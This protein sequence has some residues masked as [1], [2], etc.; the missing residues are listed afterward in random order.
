MSLH[1]EQVLA[2]RLRKTQVRRDGLIEQ[3]FDVD[4]CPGLRVVCVSARD[5]VGEIEPVSQT[6]I[7]PNGTAY[8]DADD[9]FAA[10]AQ[11]AEEQRLLDEIGG[12][13]LRHH[14]GLMRPLWEHRTPSDKAIWITRA[15]HFLGL[16][17]AIGLTIER[18]PTQ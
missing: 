6:Y 7:L 17:K 11:Q 9:A 13:L 10:W 5:E 16:A 1:S 15:R 18:R 14:H 4:H 8:E 2:A 3:V 12:I